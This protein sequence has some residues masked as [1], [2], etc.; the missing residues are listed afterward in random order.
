MLMFK[1]RLTWGDFVLG[2]PIK[3]SFSV[4]SM[5]FFFSNSEKCR[6]MTVRARERVER[7]GQSLRTETHRCKTDPDTQDNV[8]FWQYQYNKLLSYRLTNDMVL[9]LCTLKTWIKKNPVEIVVFHRSHIE[10]KSVI[11]CDPTL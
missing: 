9:T 8:F 11:F 10:I 1:C 4:K 2:S 5:F 3:D 6:S 7:K